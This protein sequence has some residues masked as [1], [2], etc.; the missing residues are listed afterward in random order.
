MHIVHVDT[1]KDFRGGQELLL[2]LAR[3]LRDRG[4]QQLIAC[5]RDSALDQRARALELD[6]FSLPGFK[7]SRARSYLAL[8]EQLKKTPF[9]IVHAHDA[10]AQTIS[11]VASAG[12]G[13]RRVASRLV[14][15]APRHPGV[16]RLK[17]RSTCDMV[18]ALSQP[19]RRA[20][21]A[22]GV[23]DRMIEVIEPGID[24]PAALPTLETR[25]RARA[26]WSLCDHHFAIGHVA[27]FTEEK[28]QAVALEAAG[29]LAERMPEARMLLAGDGPLRNAA[30]TARLLSRAGESAR[31]PGF[32]ED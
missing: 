28:G 4:H 5:P 16:H 15:F 7:P 13:I 12:L 31:L 27:A 21:L 14:A 11:A 2:T 3:G 24:P 25:R 18:I 1:G 30:G 6:V 9:E 17:Y 8:R 20:L 22:A 32:V 10:H 26:K 29:I 23:P 19:V